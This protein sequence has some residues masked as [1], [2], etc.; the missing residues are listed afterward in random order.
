M[1]D[2]KGPAWFSEATEDQV[3]SLLADI[4]CVQ[5]SLVTAV[6]TWARGT[7]EWYAGVDAL[8]VWVHD[9]AEL[10]RAKSGTC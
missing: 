10:H 5:D 9:S 3:R 4:D 8:V 6:L 1:S 2:S 7:W